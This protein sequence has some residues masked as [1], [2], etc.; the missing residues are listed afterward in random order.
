MTS[1][2]SSNA[3]RIEVLESNVVDLT[4]NL[5]SNADR[6]GVLESN[7]VD[8][9]SNLSSNAGRIEVLES[10]VVDLTSNLSS[11]AGRIGVLESNVVDLTSNL[12]S[13]AGRI[14]VLESNVV[15]LT[16]NLSSNAGRIGVLESNVVDLTSNLS[17]NAGRIGVLE[18]NVVDLTSNLSSNAGRIGV[19]ESNVVDLTSNL[20]SNAGRI[21]VLESNVVDLTSNLSSNAGRIGV[22]ESNVVDLTSNLSSNVERIGVLETKTTDISYTDGTTRISGNLT[23]LG[24]T[25]TLDTVNLIV[26]DPILQLSNASASVDSGI[27]I[28][29]PSTTDNVFVGFD[30]SLSEFAIGFTDSHAGLSEI[31][32][33]D[34]QDFTL[35]VHGNVEAS[36]FNTISFRA[37]D[38]ISNI[39]ITVAN[40]GS[41]NR[42]YI[43]GVLQQTLTLYRG[44][45]YR[46]DQADSSNSSHPFRLSTTSNGTHA[47]GSQYTDGWTTTP[48]G[49]SYNP[50]NSGAFGQYVVPTDA[51]NTL[52]YYCQ[53]HS[54]MGGAINILSGSVN[55]N[56][57]VAS[58]VSI[59]NQMD[60][61]DMNIT[62]G[63]KANGSTGSNGQVLTSSGGGAMTWTTPSSF[64]GDI[65]DYITHTGNTSND[66][67]GFPNN[68]E[69]K[70]RTGGIDRLNIDSTG[71]LTIPDYITHTGDTNTKFGFSANDTFVINTSGAVR[72][73]VNSAGE[74]TIGRNSVMGS[75]H[76]FAVVDGSTS[77]DG[78]YADLVITNMSEHNNARLL[79][80]TPHQTTS[81]SAFKAAII[82]DGAGTYSRSDLH[83]C[84]ENSNDNAANADLTDS[85]MVIK[86][87][88]GNVGI[89]VTNPG[90]PLQIAASGN[91]PFTNGL[92]VYN[93]S[94]STNQDAIV[95]LRVGGSSAGD[96]FISFDIFNEAGWT[97]G[98]DN[99][100]SNKMKWAT[101]ASNLSG[102]KM[103]LTTA[104]YLGIGTTNPTQKLQV[105]D[106]NI[107][108]SGAW[109]S[110]VYFSLMGYNNSKQ[111]QFNYD[112]GTWISDNNSIRFGV[113]GSQ[114][115][116]GLYSEQ[117]RITSGGDVG[118]GTTS[119]NYR[120]DVT[121]TVN[122]NGWFISWHYC[123]PQATSWTST[124][125]RWFVVSTVLDNGK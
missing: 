55:T 91:S 4:S 22:L 64:S 121:G 13:N 125:I 119:P 30:Q 39:T 23:V 38:V 5:S 60:I 12:S 83:F 67:F 113:G 124:Y 95:T 52:Y 16:S 65:A 36:S 107:L 71:I 58:N 15:D 41:G 57:L 35:N 100:D 43:N 37:N 28:A 73:I 110:G 46:F 112:D 123:V 86:Y 9:T 14:G 75:G 61:T 40:P 118:I 11:N 44:V 80:G 19:L 94:N 101:G 42:Y 77:N 27:L 45:T 102:T 89:G 122:F 90:T 68:N 109:S 82:A 56:G 78:S 31:A 49:L 114:S 66:L 63:L 97:F 29:R 33:K 117:M 3:G 93:N 87:D 92:M 76:M 59:Q 34:G 8:L 96:P 2:L 47:S 17:S 20:S 111:I 48:S 51:P 70:I 72:L 1:N 62:S 7:V 120:L 18:S 81:S 108:M 88:T 6:I 69:F 106:G 26:Q 10:N 53:N 32:I 84:L 25:T 98:I 54:G 116:S 24:N 99:S 85:K 21:G 74:G 50:G 115:A 103:T 104:G 79:L 105:N